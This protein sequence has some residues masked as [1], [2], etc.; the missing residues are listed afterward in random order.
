MKLTNGVIFTETEE[1]TI[2]LDAR[3]GKYWHLNPT[4]VNVLRSVL[5]GEALRDVATRLA[6]ELGADS[7][8]VLEDCQVLLRNLTEARLVK[9]A[10][11]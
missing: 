2:L 1:G 7:A 6:H 3:H 8:Q 9:G 10:S 5:A 4:G 11:N